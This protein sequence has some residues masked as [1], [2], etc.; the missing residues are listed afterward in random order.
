[1]KVRARGNKTKVRG[2]Q[3]WTYDWQTTWFSFRKDLKEKKKKKW[4]DVTMMMMVAICIIQILRIIIKFVKWWWEMNGAQ[5]CMYDVNHRVCEVGSVV[6]WQK[7]TNLRE[8]LFFSFRPISASR[9]VSLRRWYSVEWAIIETRGEG[10]HW[11]S[12]F[13]YFGVTGNKY[14]LV[15]FG[16]VK[17]E[18][19]K[20][21]KKWK[22]SERK[23][24]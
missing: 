3:I 11:L 6:Y 15:N 12:F 22:V 20:K 16:K 8:F 23:G 9:K 13:S 14:W 18:K 21:E 10:I 2:N 17:S 7:I 5:L 1:M 19:K 24:E 4:G